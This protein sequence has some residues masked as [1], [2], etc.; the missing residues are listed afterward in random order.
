MPAANAR[1]GVTTHSN[2]LS[3]A[4]LSSREGTGRDGARYVAADQPLPPAAGATLPGDA[5]PVEQYQTGTKAE[6]GR[7]PPPR[8]PPPPRIPSKP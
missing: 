4:T 7:C 2:P 3:S 5:V 6:Q 1:T 8:M